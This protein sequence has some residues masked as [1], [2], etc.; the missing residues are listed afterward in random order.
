MN[1]ISSKKTNTVIAKPSE[2]FASILILFAFVLGCYLGSSCSY[3]WN[4]IPLKSQ[5]IDKGFAEWQ[6]VNP[7]NGQ[8]EFVWK[9]SEK[10]VAMT[11][12]SL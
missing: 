11:P 5:A 2:I 3:K 4:V 9:E 7:L 12:S 8:T 10:K 1:N 6:V